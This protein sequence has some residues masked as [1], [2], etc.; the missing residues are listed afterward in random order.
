MRRRL[1]NLNALR[2]FEAAARRE[3]FKDA[4]EELNVTQSAVS[5]QVKGLEEALGVMLFRRLGRGVRATEAAHGLAAELGQSFDRIEAAVSGLAGDPMRGV[6]KVSIAPFY[7][8]RLVLPRLSRFH[9]LY[10]NIKVIPD[11]SA[12]VIDF[13][14]SDVDAGLRYG[15]GIWPGLR[16]D[17]IHEDRLVPLAAPTMIAGMEVPLPAEQ[18]ADLMLGFVEG[19]EDDWDRWFDKMGVGKPRKLDMIGYGNRARLI[20]LAFS[21][22]GAALADRALTQ[23][24]VENGHLVRLSEAEIDNGRAMW[25]VYPDGDYPDPRVL[26][27]GAWFKSEVE[28]LLSRTATDRA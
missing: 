21:G 20:D 19:D 16:A 5:H 8:N 27:F 4:A 14:K 15:K 24:D 2:A 17:K 12:S 7:G 23:Y 11:M 6:L 22:H 10:P 13:R 18:I 25:L 26:A 3:S 9:A 1:P 28:D